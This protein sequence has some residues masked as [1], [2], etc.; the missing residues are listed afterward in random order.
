MRPE[1]SHVRLSYGN[2]PLLFSNWLTINL[3]RALA[4]GTLL[5]VRTLVRMPAQT[6]AGRAGCPV[7]Q[8]TEGLP[9]NVARPLMMACWLLN[10][11]LSGRKMLVLVS[12][13]TA[14]CASCISP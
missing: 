3:F 10:E 5:M 9:G 8:G 7:R 4:A 14:F 13:G 1:A 6:A 2:S 11:T 12:K